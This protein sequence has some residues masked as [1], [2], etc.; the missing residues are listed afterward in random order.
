[1]FSGYALL[2]SQPPIQ[3]NSL[4]LRRPSIRNRLA[5]N[6]SHWPMISLIPPTVKHRHSSVHCRPYRSDPDCPISLAHVQLWPSSEQTNHLKTS[7]FLMRT[8]QTCGTRSA[9]RPFYDGNQFQSNRST[10][11]DT[12]RCTVYTELR[13][14]NNNVGQALFMID[15]S[16][17]SQPGR[18][19]KYRT[20][21]IF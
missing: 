11:I 6:D 14:P 19:G 4:M 8:H 15:D 20:I 3:H 7:P 13:P 21:A 16:H 17:S 5:T 2:G 9:L 10:R 12:F 1:M 18:L